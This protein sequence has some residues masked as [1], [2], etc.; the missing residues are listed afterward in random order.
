MSVR[1]NTKLIEDQNRRFA[2]EYER[3]QAKRIKRE[4]GIE[5]A[6]RRAA[7]VVNA[8]YKERSQSEPKS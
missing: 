8:Q 6:R 2:A 5:A 3:L 4:S 7:T 1:R